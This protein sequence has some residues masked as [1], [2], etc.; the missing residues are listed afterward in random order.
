[1]S[2]IPI[3]AGDHVGTCGLSCHLESCW[4][5]R[6]TLPQR[7]YQSEWPVQPP[8][9]MVT[10]WPGILLKT[11]SG[12]MVLPWPESV[13]MPMFLPGAMYIPGGLCYNL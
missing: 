2:V 4:F 13:L 9:T 5:L 8:G 6:T 1:M 11:M 7:P 3:T 10:F 12:S